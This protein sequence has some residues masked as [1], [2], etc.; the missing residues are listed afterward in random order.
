MV[1][2]RSADFDT[3]PTHSTLW[4]CVA[5]LDGEILKHL[6]PHKTVLPELYGICI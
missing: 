5:T 4:R 3:I 6:G 1:H 2:C